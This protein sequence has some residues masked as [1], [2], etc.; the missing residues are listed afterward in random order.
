MNKKFK[1]LFL[2]GALT[3]GL[4]GVAVSCT[5]YSKDIDELREE[6]TELTST[7]KDL[8]DKIKSG[9][10]IT[11]VKVTSDGLVITTS[12]GK[13]YNVTNGKDGAKGDTGAT[14]AQGEKGEKGDKGDTGAQGEKG[15][16]GDTGAA[17]KDGGYYK[18][19][20]D[21]FWYYYSGPDAAGEKT[22][23]TVFPVGTITAAI[24]DGK[25]VLN[26][27][28]G[29]EGGKVTLD[30]EK[31]ISSLVFIPQCYVD[32]VE[33]MTYSSMSYNALTSSKLD[34][35]EETWSAANA[36]SY[37]NPETVAEYH[38]NAAGL[39]LDETYTY[40]FIVKNVKFYKT[41]RAEASKDFNVT[42]T[43]ESFKDGILKVK[44]AVT[45][46]EA[47][48]DFISV[49]ALKAVKKGIVVVSDYATLYRNNIVSPVIAWP[50][51]VSKVSENLGKSE[52]AHFRRYIATLD[53]EAFLKTQL[54]WSEGHDKIDE[55]HATCD[56]AVAYN[57]T[58]DLKTIVAAHQKGTKCAEVSAA[59]LDKYGL[60]WQFDLVKNYK[61]GSPVT[62]QADFATIE[63]GVFTPK[64]YNT[65]GQASIGRTP[66]VRVSLKNGSSVVA[67]AYIKV[68]IKS[69]AAPGSEIPTYELKPVD[70]D[71]KNLFTFTCAD[72]VNVL[73][74]TVEE[75]NVKIY[76]ELG[77]SKDQ[78]HALYN[79]FKSKAGK[80]AT[81]NAGDTDDV[82]NTDSEATHV[83][84]WTLTTDEIFALEAGA[85]V[86]HIC[87][88][89]NDKD[90]KLAVN[91]KLTATVDDL[92]ALKVYN[93]TTAEYIKEYWTPVTYD[94]TIYNVA[95]PAAGSVDAS[96]CIYNVDINA[97][98]NTVREGADKGKIKLDSKTPIS[99]V[100]YF[101]CK[102]M[103]DIKKVGGVDV[104]FT[105]NSDATVLY[106]NGEEIARIDNTPSTTPWNV[107]TYV[108]NEKAM[109]LLNTGVM[110]VKISA[111]AYVCG[112]KNTKRAVKL[113]FN[114]TENDHFDAL[115]KQ[116]V[117]IGTE[118][119]VPFTDGVDFG[120]AGSYIDIAKV[121]NPS[122][123]RK[124]SFADNANYWQYYGP[125]VITFDLANAE[126][127][128]NGEWAKVPATIDLNQ[129]EPKSNVIKSSKRTDAKVATVDKAA[130]Y[131]YL[132]YCNNSVVVDNFKIRIKA[133]VQYGWG[134]IVTDWITINVNKTE[135]QGPTTDQD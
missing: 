93:V 44:V 18:P 91:V 103:V 77:L 120:K 102:D 64:V 105:L 108:K 12:D 127:F 31:A 88:Y 135:G 125:F 42:P 57:Q 32:G 70:N 74:T 131:G 86:T 26:N 99:G 49:V 112:D 80:A 13:T 67:V 60:T 124:Y 47:T 3:L 114:G 117:T 38:V 34:S 9:C 119:T 134:T 82:V 41:T 72:G 97:S 46:T 75:M 63:D 76:N 66:I 50:T 69:P 116:P 36:I 27:V 128:L 118:S 101:F 52:D 79:T 61:I 133:K 20:A 25:L 45:G 35:K 39:E 68:F 111:K 48:G 33:G 2:A 62:D 71:G 37:I 23:I 115:I 7:I 92:S 15:D 56:T 73:Y 14:G 113:T 16:K 96:K 59:E 24:V 85:A 100:E 8:Q 40:S 95:V 81:E 126:A 129:S 130:E 83:I 94:Q 54:V 1:N 58:L 107:F 43:F 106:D 78:F 98:F 17:G 55:A 89:Y 65:A 132:T 5:D 19:N 109:T 51:A 123:W 121:I 21:G 4:V 122:D 87:Q 104:K 90:P 6:N 10:V 28:A 30:I 22:D 53:P 29:V 84:K 110:V 11:D